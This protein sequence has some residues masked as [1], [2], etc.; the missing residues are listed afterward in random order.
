VIS[1]RSGR[2]EIILPNV[3]QIRL[4]RDHRGVDLISNVLPFGR[5]W[6]DEP[7]AIVG[8]RVLPLLHPRGWLLV[9]HGTQR[10]RGLTPARLESPIRVRKT[11]SAFHQRA[12]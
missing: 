11:Q 4:R 3:Y 5:L 6:Y 9:F 1:M 10:L 12:Q 8:S 2:N 7:N